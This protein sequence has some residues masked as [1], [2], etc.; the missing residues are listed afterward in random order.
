MQFQASLDSNHN[1]ECKT[2]RIQIVLNSAGH[3]SSDTPNKAWSCEPRISQESNCTRNFKSS[4]DCYDSGAERR[5]AWTISQ[6]TPHV[7]TLLRIAAVLCCSVLLPCSA[8]LCFALL[9]CSAL[10][11]G[12]AAG[13]FSAA[14]PCSLALCPALLLFSALCCCT[15]LCS[16]LL[17]SALLC[18]SLLSSPPLCSLLLCPALL[19]NPVGCHCSTMLCSSPLLS[20]CLFGFLCLT[21]FI[22][23]A[24]LSYPPLSHLFSSLLLG[25]SMFFCPLPCSTS[26]ALLCFVLISSPLLCSGLLCS[27]AVLLCRPPSPHSSRLALGSRFLQ[28]RTNIHTLAREGR[29][30]R[31]KRARK[32]KQ[33]Q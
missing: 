19:L 4:C 18:S 16:A 1:S 33:G 29:Q 26:S 20:S 10:L 22:C 25:V 31:G 27:A 15:L 13:L 3:Q 21:A 23:C 32:E 12:C 17:S 9:P 6:A 5:S 24:L 30:T 8:L 28:A 7:T 2:T 11:L 14:V